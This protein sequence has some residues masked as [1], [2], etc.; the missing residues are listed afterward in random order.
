MWKEKSVVYFRA[1]S[2]HF[3]ESWKNHEK[4]VRICDLGVEIRSQF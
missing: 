2:E 1:S 3:L 4:A